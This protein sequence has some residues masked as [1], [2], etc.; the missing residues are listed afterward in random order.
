M[1]VRFAV[2]P[3]PR[4]AD[5]ARFV[6]FVDGLERLGFDAIWLSDI[7]IGSTFD[8]LVALGVTAG[9]TTRLKLGANIVPFGHNPIVL[10]KALA[11]L[12][13]L[14]GGRVLLSFVPGL[15][16]PAERAALGLEGV[17]RGER[18]DDTVALLRALWSGAPVDAGGPGYAAEGFVLPALPVQ[19]PLEIWLGGM[20]PRA[21]ER[22][23]RLSDGWL[24]ASMTPA[25]AAAAVVTIQHAAA[26]AGRGID[27][28]HFGLSLAYAREQPDAAVL[29]ALATR[30]PDV[31]PSIL[32]PVGA[33]GIRSLIES[34]IDAGLSK[35]VLRPNPAVDGA[36]VDDEL[37]WLADAILP[38]QT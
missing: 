33:A 8:P 20:G 4:D 23:G 19:Q 16:Q 12:D 17:D 18:M 28:D 7:P 21:L 26:E 36:T 32:L 13:Q 9:R 34:L 35:F 25:E 10:A 30:R 31:D 15:G 11:Q 3:A 24:G 1:K 2:A 5:P 29:A 6:S 27:P 38:L 14:S 37:T 22:A